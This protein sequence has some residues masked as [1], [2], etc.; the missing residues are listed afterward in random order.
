MFD[1]EKKPQGLGPNF[2]RL[3][4]YLLQLLLSY[5]AIGIASLPVVHLLTA[6]GVSGKH[7]HGVY[8]AGYDLLIYA[9][10]AG[11]VIGWVSVRLA[12]VLAITGRWIW[13]PPVALWLILWIGAT[14]V[15]H[16]YLPE[17]FFA[18]GDNEG[19]GVFFVSRPAFAAIGYS[20]GAAGAKWVISRTSGGSGWRLV[21]SYAALLALFA[22]LVP[23][24]RRLEDNRLFEA[25]THPYVVVHSVSLEESPEAVCRG[26]NAGTVTIS[27]GDKVDSGE[28]RACIGQGLLDPEAD[29]PAESILVERVKVRS[30]PRT[31]AEGWVPT[32]ALAVT[33]YD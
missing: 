32:A 29:F 7:P 17:Q 1:V 10:V 27:T 2:A 26:T 6:I 8:F 20:L 24:M 15:S 23:F 18:T 14:S 21:L 12:P 30:G 16:R 5:P 28:Q 11:P 3:V 4:S 25:N 19:L 22:A 9:L 13:L 31:G 33:P